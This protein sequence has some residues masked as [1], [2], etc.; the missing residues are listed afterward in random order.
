M[1]TLYKISEQCNRMILNF[2]IEKN[3]IENDK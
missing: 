2:D 1:K 3:K